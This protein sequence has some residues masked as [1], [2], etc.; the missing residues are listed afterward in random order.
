MNRFPGGSNCASQPFQIEIALVLT[1]ENFEGL[2]LLSALF[3]FLSALESKMISV[4]S[5][6]VLKFFRASKLILE[7]SAAS[8]FLVPDKE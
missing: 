8:R 1:A 3:G 6:K 4:K 2:P 5:K 7:S